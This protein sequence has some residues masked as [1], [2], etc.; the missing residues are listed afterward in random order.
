M[1]ITYTIRRICYRIFPLLGFAAL[2]ALTA[3]ASMAKQQGS[4]DGTKSI[5]QFEECH[6]KGV[7]SISQCTSLEVPENHNDPDGKKISLH[8]VVLPPSGGQPEFEPLYFFAGGPGQA[9][10][11]QGLLYERVLRRARQGRDL[12]IIDQRGTGKSNPFMCI[13]PNNPLASGSDV[14]NVCL[15]DIPQDPTQYTSDAFIKDVDMVREALGHD[16]IS[17]MGISYG[18][19]AALLYAKA[20]EDHVRAM[21]LDSVAPPHKLIFSNEALYAGNILTK[22]VDDCKTDTDCNTAFP[23]LKQ[24]FENLLTQLEAEPITLKV[25]EADEFDITVNRELFLMG[26]RGSLYAPPAARMLPII[27]NNA[28]KG[29]FGPWL[30]ITDFGNQELSGGIS[31]GLILS[32]QCA[33]EISILKN[34]EAEITPSVFPSGYALF[35]K[36]ACNTWPTGKAPDGFNN[37]V[38]VA[39]PT[40]LLSGGLDPITPPEMGDAATEHLSNAK[41]LVAENAGHSVVGYGCTRLIIAEFLDHANPEEVDGE[42]LQKISKPAFI[43]ARYGTKP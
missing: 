16:Q 6:L 37:P 24:D 41:H 5:L 38:K 20:H 32:V 14:A 9:A 18:T 40:L 21:V 1:T 35:W 28:A 33:E 2:T 31:M 17:L 8:I 12:V 39:T 7:E 29:N 43:V 13:P 36:E 10:S 11:E 42:C 34:R 23:N 25:P 3:S 15:K 4:G 26:F 19:R 30:A 27:I 22:V